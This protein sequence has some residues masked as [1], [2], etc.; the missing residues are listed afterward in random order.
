MRYLPSS[1]F[2]IHIGFL[3]SSTVAVANTPNIETKPNQALTSSYECPVR[4]I[5]SFNVKPLHINLNTVKDAIYLEADTGKIVSQGTST[6]NGNVTIQQ[7]TTIFSANSALFNRKTNE[8][9]AQGNV[10]LSD[11]NFFLKSPLINYNLEKQSGV[12]SDAEYAI[13][14]AGLRGKSAQIQQLDKKQNIWLTCSNYARV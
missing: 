5:Q 3:I 11:T 8:V 1:I 2:F 10:I 13:G 14:K 9:T 4:D 12:I 7:N 6:L